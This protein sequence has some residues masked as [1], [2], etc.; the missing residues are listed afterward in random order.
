MDDG[1]DLFKERAL[2]LMIAGLLPGCLI[3]IYWVLVR[4][5]AFPGNLLT[6]YSQVYL[7]ELQRDWKFWVFII[8]LPYIVVMPVSLSLALILQCRIAVRHVLGDNCSATRALGMLAKPF[9]SLFIV[10]LVFGAMELLV[11]V[12]ALI[13]NMIIMGIFV[14]I[15]GIFIYTSTMSGT[16]SAVGFIIIAIGY[17][18]VFAIDSVIYLGSCVL[19]LSAPVLLAHEHHGPFKAIG[20]SFNIAQANFKA[21]FLALLVIVHAP[22]IML[23]MLSS[24]TGIVYALMRNSFPLSIEIITALFMLVFTAACTGLFSCLGALAYVDGRCRRDMLDLQLLAADI[25]LGETFARLYMPGLRMPQ[26]YYPNY[27]GAP[28]QSAMMPSPNYAAPPP[29]AGL[30]PV[31][32]FPDYSAPPPLL[33]GPA[34]TARTFPDYSAPPPKLEPADT[35]PTQA[36][37]APPLLEPVD[38]PPPEP[39]G[40]VKTEGETETDEQR[41]DANAP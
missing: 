24:I 32:A 12:V 26:P 7:E 4:T 14:A 17:A 25:G 1:F 29:G 11:G 20:Q 39:A 33:G 21:H 35:M 38:A 5:F 31:S 3:A 27:T 15:G 10:Y 16:I 8:V 28:G 23:V 41:E 6:E 9:F 34:P 37:A 40:W 2:D 19:F 36:A 13:V 18:I 30:P 22:V